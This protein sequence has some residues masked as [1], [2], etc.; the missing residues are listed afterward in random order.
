MPKLQV[1]LASAMGTAGPPVLMFHVSK[2]DVEIVE[3]YPCASNAERD[4]GE[5]GEV[6]VYLS[7]QLGK[8]DLME[9]QKAR[10]SNS[11]PLQFTCIS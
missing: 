9:F 5:K 4:E 2:F 10:V 7:D 6:N 11:F 1:N 3:H 8:C